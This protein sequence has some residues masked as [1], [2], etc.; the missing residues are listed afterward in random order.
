MAEVEPPQ[1]S[2]K[3]HVLY[4][5]CHDPIG[6]IRLWY[7][8]AIELEYCHVPQTTEEIEI[9]DT[10]M[11][12]VSMSKWVHRAL[13]DIATNQN[14]EVSVRMLQDH[15][16]FLVRTGQDGDQFLRQVSNWNAKCVRPLIQDR[17]SAPCSIAGNRWVLDPVYARPWFCMQLRELSSL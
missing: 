17:E 9:T 7:F 16:T 12:T 8:I 15:Y 13:M 10:L 11:S 2:A 1:W 6:E 14:P 3:E 4:R 5:L